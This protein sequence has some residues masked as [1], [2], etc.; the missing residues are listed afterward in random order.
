MNKITKYGG[1]ALITGAS[2][3]IG[4]EFAR[5]IA[6]RNVNCVL[7]ARRADRL[8]EL[9]AELEGQHGV[10]CRCIELDLTADDAVDSLQKATGDIPIGILV[11]NA[12]FGYAGNFETRDPE[13]LKALV[14]LNC[15]VPILLTRAF[16]PAMKERK[17]GAVI[18]VASIVGF[19]PA[20]FDSTYSA[21][22]AFDL[23]FGESLWG[24]LRGTGIDVITLCPAVTKTEFFAVEGLDKQQEAKVLKNGDEPRPIVE[25]T[26]R[27]L[28]RQPSVGPWSASYPAL[29]ARMLPRKWV[30]WIM[31]RMMANRSD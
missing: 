25:L 1:W 31:S 14:N 6:A 3:G 24:E 20:P 15:L 30:A 5:S 21:S 11:N 7:V 13:R 22:K 16:L 10:S 18:M 19:L 9:A 26:L 28:G 17:T 4:K 23:Y 27:R 2:S 8:R 12:G 29:I